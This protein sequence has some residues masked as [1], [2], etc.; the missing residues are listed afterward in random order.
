[1]NEEFDVLFKD[2]EHA[3]LARLFIDHHVTL[4]K[5]VRSLE[6]WRWIQAGG[7]GIIALLLYPVLA[8]VKW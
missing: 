6:R 5:R 1:M 7:G 8:H 3:A 2:V 4:E